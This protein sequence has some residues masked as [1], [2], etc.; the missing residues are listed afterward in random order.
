MIETTLK[1]N[2]FEFGYLY[3]AIKP[4]A[5]DRMPR[6]LWL[7]M[8]IISS[9]AYLTHAKLGKAALKDVKKYKKQLDELQNLK[10]V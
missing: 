7:K 6:T 9:S 4:E 5:W 1:I 2:Y 3:A 8:N 10:G